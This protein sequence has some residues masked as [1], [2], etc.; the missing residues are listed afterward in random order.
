M[1]KRTKMAIAAGLV[2]LGLAVVPTVASAH[3]LPVSYV[4]NATTN[5][6][7]DWYL[8]ES[9]WSEYWVNNCSHWPPG[10]LHKASCDA[11]VKGTTYGDLRCPSYSSHCYETDTTTTCWKRVHA[12][13][14]GRSVRYRVAYPHCS[15]TTSTDRF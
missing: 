15:S 2:L 10:N 3:K 5:V 13:L 7:V 1:K 12:T 8:S 9:R 4:Q 11:F 14:K 6:A